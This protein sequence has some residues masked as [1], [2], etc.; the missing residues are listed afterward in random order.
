M[1]NSSLSYSA[2]FQLPGLCPRSFNHY[3]FSCWKKCGNKLIFPIYTQSYIL[4][5]SQSTLKK[6]IGTSF[7][8]CGSLAL[9]KIKHAPLPLALRENLPV[10]DNEKERWRDWMGETYDCVH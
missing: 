1:E 6:N 4:T 9:Q 7:W 5:G 2:S 10:A 8:T 3:L